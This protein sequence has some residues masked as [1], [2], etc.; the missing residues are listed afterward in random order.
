MGHHGH[1]DREDLHDVFIGVWSLVGSRLGV[2]REVR[3]DQHGRTMNF[4]DVRSP[5]S[6]VLGYLLTFVI[7][8]LFICVNVE[9]WQERDQHPGPLRTIFFTL[10]FFTIGM[11]SNFHK[12]MEEGIGR[13]AIVYVVC[14]SA[15]S[16]A[17]AC[18]SRGCS[19][20]A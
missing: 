19:S 17:S 14:L 2:D 13:F 20:T 15:S 4:G 7:I 16:F 10:T 11:V 8:K 5:V 9:H 18:S 12:L 1:H 6:A 3:Q